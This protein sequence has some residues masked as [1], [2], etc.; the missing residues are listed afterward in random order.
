MVLNIQS[1]NLEMYGTERLVP[2]HRNWF[3]TESLAPE[4]GIGTHLVP[5]PR[6]GMVLN[7]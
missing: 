2:K 4:H 3:G 7:A 6:I 5:E 1:L